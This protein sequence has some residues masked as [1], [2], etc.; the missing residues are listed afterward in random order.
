[1]RGGLH[2]PI[3]RDLY[4]NPTSLKARNAFDEHKGYSV[5]DMGASNFKRDGA[6]FEGHD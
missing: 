1:M 4:V 3:E 6:S 2:L 5:R